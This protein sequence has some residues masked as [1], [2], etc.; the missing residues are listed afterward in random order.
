[1]ISAVELAASG[2]VERSSFE[3]SLRNGD[4]GG[5]SV[6][7]GHGLPVT[8]VVKA[9]KCSLSQWRARSTSGPGDLNL[10]ADI[11]E[12]FQLGRLALIRRKNAH[13]RAFLAAEVVGE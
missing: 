5:G 10:T 12:C 7:R 1:M 13:F 2:K 9:L 11:I 4:R 6:N 3:E 8:V